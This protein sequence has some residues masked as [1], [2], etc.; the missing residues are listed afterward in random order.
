MNVKSFESLHIDGD[1]ELWEFV[2]LCFLLAPVKSLF[3]IRDQA[4]D[5]GERSTVAPS[6]IIK[7]VW[8]NCGAQFCC[9]V[10]SCLSSIAIVNGLMRF[11]G[12]AM[13]V[14]GDISEAW[15]SVLQRTTCS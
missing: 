11:S 1:Q 13:A 12:A 5:F 14:E 8:K 7:L 2:Q 4:L 3:S 10:A 9:S 6:R 15:D